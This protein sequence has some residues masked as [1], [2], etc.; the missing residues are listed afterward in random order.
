MNDY[1]IFQKAAVSVK[2]S[3]TILYLLLLALIIGSWFL[4][5]I[6]LFEVNSQRFDVIFLFLSIAQVLGFLLLFLLLAQGNK[7]M[8][9]LYWI[10]F[11]LN[12]CA[13]Y[14]PI[15]FFLG[16][17]AG[18]YT[19][20]AWAGCLLIEDVL[21]YNV[22]TYL[23]SN[24]NC[25]VYYDHVLEMDEETYMQ[26]LQEEARARQLEAMKQAQMKQSQMVQPQNAEPERLEPYTPRYLKEQ[27]MESA[28][29]KTRIIEPNA[30]PEKDRQLDLDEM[31]ETAYKGKKQLTIKQRLQRLSVKLGICVYGELIIFP[32]I[33]SLFSDYFVSTDMKS[34]FAT[35]D[36]FILCIASAFIWT[37]AIFFLYYAS[38]QSKKAVLGCWIGEIAVNCWYI[39]K[40]IGYI[41]STMPAYPSQ[42]FIFFII[43]DIIRYALIILTISPIY[44]MKKA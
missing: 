2:R 40:M 31:E 8:R 23:Y 7:Y 21:L 30:L 33:V 32:I 24:S 6:N 1:K 5:H 22:G 25:K 14:F 35:R 9:I 18:I 27:P 19:W 16:D 26:A 13:I 41:H 42:V 12:G 29:E 20:I 34:V 28:I 44:L 10:G 39:P 3:L 17:H 15:S 4:L 43:L 36:I 38:S 37:F 11:I